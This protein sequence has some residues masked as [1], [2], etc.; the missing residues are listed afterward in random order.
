MTASALGVAAGL[1]PE[2]GIFAVAADLLR[3]AEKPSKKPKRAA[4][5]KRSASRK[6]RKRS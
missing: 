3:R 6:G 5:R 4:P 2:S 1:G